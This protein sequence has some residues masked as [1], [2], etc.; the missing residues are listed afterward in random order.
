MKGNAIGWRLMFVGFTATA[1]ALGG[2]VTTRSIGHAAVACPGAQCV[3]VSDT[4]T[5]AAWNSD[6]TFAGGANQPGA[7]SCFDGSGHPIA[8]STVPPTTACE[9]DLLNVGLS[10]ANYWTTHNGGVEIKLFDNASDDFDVFVWPCSGTCTTMANGTKVGTAPIAQGTASNGNGTPVNNLPEEDLHLTQPA[11][12]AYY[13]EVIP[14]A[15]PVGTYNMTADFQATVPQGPP[16]PPP[17][18]CV[19]GSD[20]LRDV[21]A[22]FDQIDTVGTLYGPI[23]P[24]PPAGCATPCPVSPFEPDTQIEPSIAVNPLNPLNAVATF[25]QGRADHGAS[26][27]T[28]WATTKDGGQTWTTGNVP[29]LTLHDIAP[30]GRANP[31]D[32]PGTYWERASDPVVAFG[33]NNIVYQNSLLI[34]GDPDTTGTTDAGLSLNESLDGGLTWSMPVFFHVSTLITAQNLPVFGHVFDDKNW[35]TVDT[36]TSPTSHPGRVYAVWDI[37]N[38]HLYAYCDPVNLA[39]PGTDC[40]NLANWTT[41]ATNFAAFNQGGFNEVQCRCIGATPVVLNNGGLMVVLNDFMLGQQ[42][43]VTAPLAGA[44]AWPAPLT[45][46]PEVVIANVTSHA[47]PEQRAGPTFP[48]VAI[49][50]SSGTTGKVYVAWADT[51]F[52]TDT[53]TKVND[54]VFI[55]SDATTS[56]VWGSV[57]RIN[58]GPTNDHLDS[59]NTMIGVSPDGTLRASY[60]LR[61]ETG[62]A[63][64][65]SLIFT[66]YQFSTNQGAKWSTPLKVDIPN[67]DDQYCAFSRGACFLGDYNQL[68]TGNDCLVTSQ[69]S[70]GPYTYIVR[71]ES[72]A[73]FPG[74][75][76]NNVGGMFVNCPTPG[77]VN[78]FACHTHQYTWVAV[79]GPGQN[80]NNI[81]EAPLIAG[82]TL[83]GLAATGLA[84]AIRRRRNK[85]A[86]VG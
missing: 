71:D 58:N 82:L 5:H 67:T 42:V 76:P 32:C 52:R 37:V 62:L 8:S 73:S 41:V 31:A 49:D 1:L 29:G 15:T 38:V 51:N 68:A 44:T 80:N 86:P 69:G 20:C 35:I 33:P 40:M 70:C 10:S 4:S 61:D 54:A 16:P 3:T 45:F 78:G 39:N 14:F 84:V 17:P 75:A 36:G 85:G 22:S 83:T 25:Q 28:G 12:G 63:P 43:E 77:A 59:F 11:A 50:R 34:K 21:K 2:L 65:T 18:G 7:G 13:I 47:V 23:N 30:C 56:Q 6:S 79:I 72:Y 9:V 26:A 19:P 60:R 74:E 64:Y 66:Y 55:S 46:G 57:T 48:Q 53:P 27:G 81:A 24:N